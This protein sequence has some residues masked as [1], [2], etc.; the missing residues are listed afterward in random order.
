MT[1]AISELLGGEKQ[2]E[3]QVVLEDPAQIKRL[4]KEQSN[5]LKREQVRTVIT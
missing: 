4:A 2:K 1:E 3:E 5:A